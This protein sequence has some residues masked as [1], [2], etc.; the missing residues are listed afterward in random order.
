MNNINQ[1]VTASGVQSDVCCENNGVDCNCHIDSKLMSKFKF[2]EE[3]EYLLY[4]DSYELKSNKNISIQVT[5]CAGFETYSINQNIP[6]QECMVHYPEI[7]TC[8]EKA[9]KA[10]LK[11]VVI[12]SVSQ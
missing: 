9:M 11:K 6:R 8:L 3:E 1:Y 12:V 2:N 7:Y 4:D 5:E 10:A